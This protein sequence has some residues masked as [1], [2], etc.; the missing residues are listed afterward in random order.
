MSSKS[1]HTGKSKYGV[2]RMTSFAYVL[3][4]IRIKYGNHFF[5]TFP[6]MHR[7]LFP[8]MTGFGVIKF[9]NDFPGEP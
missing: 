2:S 8:N 1:L 6:T 5:D 4:S 7:F 9:I 3:S